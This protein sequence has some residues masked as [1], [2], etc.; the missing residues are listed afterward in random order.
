MTML[1]GAVGQ[2]LAH[3]IMNNV[4]L[5]VWYNAGLATALLGHVPLCIAYGYV[6]ER[7]GLASGWDWAI[8]FAYAVF[9]YVAV[10][11]MLIMKSLED[12]NSPVS[13]RRGRT[14]SL[15]QA[16]RSMRESAWM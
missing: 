9:A 14:A 11:R 1:F 7:D 3:G 2:T 13:I 6:I 5:K 15:R 8:G 16:L 10:F 12:K 4:K